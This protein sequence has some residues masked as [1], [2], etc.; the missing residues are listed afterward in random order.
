MTCN[1]I[2]VIRLY[3]TA[4]AT[5]QPEIL[6]QELIIACM[7]T[8]LVACDKELTQVLAYGRIV[9]SQEWVGI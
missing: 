7:A 5:G 3:V 6:K 1:I 2:S 8:S 9:W 4:S